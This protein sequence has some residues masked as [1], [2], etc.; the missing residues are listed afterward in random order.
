M[1]GSL[2]S[3]ARSA[4]L[5]LRAFRANLQALVLNIQPELFGYRFPIPFH[6]G[7]VYFVDGIAIRADYLG[8][9]VFG[10]QV[11]GVELVVVTDVHLADHPAFYEQGEAPVDGGARNGVV[12]VASMIEKLFGREVSVLLEE[13]IEYPPALTRDSEPFACEESGKAIPSFLHFLTLFAFSHM[14]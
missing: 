11:D 9:E 6:E 12:Q 4:L 8:L 3:V 10:A 2:V 1:L 14:C 13:G 5:E 7:S